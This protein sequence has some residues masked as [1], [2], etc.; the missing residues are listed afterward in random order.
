MLVKITKSKIKPIQPIS[1]NLSFSVKSM[2]SVVGAVVGVAEAAAGAGPGIA[3]RKITID[4]QNATKG[5]C[6][7][8]P[9]YT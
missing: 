3:S 5:Y 6:M 1:F 8:N 2:Q 7:I 4:I 9:R